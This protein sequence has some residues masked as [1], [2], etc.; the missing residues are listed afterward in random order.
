MLL[1]PP[2]ENRQG[3]GTR[4][5]VGG[6][7]THPSKIAKGGAASVLVPIYPQWIPFGQHLRLEIPIRLEFRTNLHEELAAVLS[8]IASAH[9]IFRDAAADGDGNAVASNRL[10]ARGLHRLRVRRRVAD[11]RLRGGIHPA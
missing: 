10:C 3:W 6:Q 2:F 9:G 1:H 7:N 11:R 5:R 8:S 4:I